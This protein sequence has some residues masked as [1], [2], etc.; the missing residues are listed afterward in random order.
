[1]MFSRIQRYILLKYISALA[2]V[3]GIFMLTIMLV[4]TVEQLRTVGGDVDLSPLT[5]VWFAIMKLPGLIEQTFPFAILVAAMIAYNQLSK[6]SELSVIRASGQSA[7][8]FLSPVIIFAALLG[9]FSMMVL[10]PLGAQL[11]ERFESARANV[12]Q[13]GGQRVEVEGENIWL[14]QGSDDSQ[15]LIYAAKVDET[16]LVFQDVKFVEEGR[17]FENGQATNDFAFVRRIDAAEA[18]IID[19]FWQLTDLVENAP[20]TEPRIMDSLA[21]ETDLDPNTLLSRF[22]SPNTIGFWRL[23]GFI[24]QTTKAGLDASRFTMR[25]FG[26]TALPV[27]YIAMALIGALVCLR[28]S[29]LGGTSRL[30]ATG[31]IA[32]IGLFFVNEVAASLGASGGVPPAI[33]A[34]APALC[35]LFVSLT[36]LSYQEDG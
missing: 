14:R 22:T 5:A 29:R 26:L 21:I 30:V 19:G 24:D 6:S 16:G 7:W 31:A 18:R 17:V 12:L 23:P 10:N 15:I 33:A 11:S 35:A 32:A 28:L 13:E 25:W 34:W 20:D 9:L 27:L 8:Q 1:M 3:L 36:I 4:D 2:L